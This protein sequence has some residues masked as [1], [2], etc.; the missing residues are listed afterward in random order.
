MWISWECIVKMN[1]K[2]GIAERQ[3]EMGGVCVTYQ[4]A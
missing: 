1:I 2:R 3:T 4:G